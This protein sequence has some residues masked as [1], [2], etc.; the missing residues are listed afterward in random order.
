MRVQEDGMS[1]QPTSGADTVS[2]D[3]ELSGPGWGLRARLT[4]P[5]GPTDRLGLLPM[6]RALSDA[7]S[8]MA[9][10]SSERQGRPVSCRAGCAACC[11]QIV[12]ASEAEARRLRA[13]VEALPE[14]KRAEVRARFAE[15][16]RKLEEAGL[17][18]ALQAPE[19]FGPGVAELGLAYFRL[20]LDCPF[21]EEERCTIYPERPL[22]CREY[23]VV[24]P[25]ESC[26]RP[27]V[28]T[29]KQLRLPFKVSTAFARLD[30]GPAEERPL[31]RLPLILAPEWAEQHPDEPSARPGPEWAR[32]L[33]ENVTGQVIPDPPQQGG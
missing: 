10:R 18:E 15:A 19:S 30:D 11:R 26:S 24:S 31:R 28:E 14:P 13:L 16:R 29:V 20:R 7:A 2:G 5:A 4:V 27:D 22:A 1:D 17:L 32:M 33:L 25:A 21:L 23:L 3:V 9:Q 6:V 12:L 8:D